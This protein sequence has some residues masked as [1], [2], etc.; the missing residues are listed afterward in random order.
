VLKRREELDE[1]EKQLAALA[2]DR[3]ASAR[4][5]RDLKTLT[6]RWSANSAYLTYRQKRAMLYAFGVKVEVWAKGHTPRY[7]ISR[8]FEGLQTGMDV[9]TFEADDQQVADLR[10]GHIESLTTCSSRRGSCRRP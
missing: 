5:I 9:S 2:V 3:Y 6:K 8:D 1:A 4:Q 10:A 7:L